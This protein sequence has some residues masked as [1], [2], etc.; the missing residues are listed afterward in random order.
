MV[1]INK[2]VYRANAWMSRHKCWIGF[3]SPRTRR[4]PDV[5]FISWV[6]SVMH[7]TH[8]TLPLWCTGLVLY[9]P[10]SPL[11]FLTF[12]SWLIHKHMTNED[13][14]FNYNRRPLPVYSLL[15]PSTLLISSIISTCASLRSVT[16]WLLTSVLG[17]LRC[18]LRIGELLCFLVTLLNWGVW[19][20]VVVLFKGMKI[21]T[22]HAELS[23]INCWNVDA[24]VVPWPSS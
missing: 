3:L 24:A 12:S 15:P 14:R 20:R 19:C 2:P 13:S 18:R 5:C 7:Q 21:F 10:I 4:R 8:H 1:T 11:E 9:V 16:D 22:C 17:C 6:P 23:L